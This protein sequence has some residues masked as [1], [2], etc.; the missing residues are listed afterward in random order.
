MTYA[1][2]FTEEGNALSPLI[3]FFTKVGLA[4]NEQPLYR[5]RY[6]QPIQV[7]YVEG[8]REN[9]IAI[10]VGQLASDT[11]AYYSQIT[12]LAIDKSV[13]QDYTLPDIALTWGTFH[14]GAVNHIIAN[15]DSDYIL[16]QT[17]WRLE[18]VR[19]DGQEADLDIERWA[20]CAEGAQHYYLVEVN[21]VPQTDGHQQ[22]W[23]DIQSYAGSFRVIR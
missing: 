6:Q 10:D 3:L 23:D 8:S 7:R 5:L 13:A 11:A 21:Y 14:W 4:W 20:L 12:I 18:N 15:R 22:V 2:L 9:G 19:V 17:T 16:M 1:D